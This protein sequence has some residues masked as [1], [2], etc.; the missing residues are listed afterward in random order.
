M[1]SPRS[2]PPLFAAQS[3]KTSRLP[4]LN[5]HRAPWQRSNWIGE[6]GMEGSAIK[7]KITPM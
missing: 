1:M 6:E 7:Q 2:L 4:G 5:S 3:L